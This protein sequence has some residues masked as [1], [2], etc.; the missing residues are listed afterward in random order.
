MGL[1][2]R[3]CAPGLI[4]ALALAATVPLFPADSG[5]ILRSGAASSGA[6]LKA[7]KAA[8]A[9]QTGLHLVITSRS[10]SSADKE[11]VVADLGTKS[12]SETI[13][14]AKEKVR[15]R[16]TSHFGYISGN[17]SGLTEIIGLNSSEASALGRDW[18]SVKAGTTQYKDLE[19]GLTIPSIS[20][21]LPKAAGTKLSTEANA[22]LY[23]L[24]WSTAATST[25]PK[26]SSTLTLSSVGS[27]L[28][29]TE[30]TDAATGHETVAFSNW[31]EQVTVSTPPR[32]ST[33]PSSKIVG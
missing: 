29:V 30:T 2:A 12:G 18:M 7:A 9:K 14:V 33:V 16:I 6:V 32:R 28:P 19:A 10:S 21:V 27:P 15:I 23:L 24:K 31:G 20:E 4:G 5:K 8:M 22:K 25:T 11:L 3:S 17:S 13:S 26:L 1:L